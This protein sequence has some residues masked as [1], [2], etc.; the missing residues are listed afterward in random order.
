MEGGGDAIGMARCHS[1]FAGLARL[2][3]S[4]PLQDRSSGVHL[5][6][7][8]SHGSSPP[9]R[10]SSRPQ[11]VRG[12][13]QPGPSGLKLNPDEKCAAAQLKVQRLEAA[14]GAFGD[15]SSPESR[16]RSRDSSSQG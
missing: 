15:E 7:Q 6:Q 14:L 1:R 12:P 11:G 4:G 3:T 8:F 5:S 13:Q 2:H 10:W 16:M 9:R